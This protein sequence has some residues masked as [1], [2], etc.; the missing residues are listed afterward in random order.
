LNIKI[1]VKEKLIIVLKGVALGVANKVPGISGGLVAFV[2]GFY[3]EFIDSLQKFNV[4]GVK[5]IKQGKFK[6][7]Y[8]HINGQFLGLLLFGMI[9]SYFSVSRILDYLLN[10]Y[11][12]YVWSLFFG[13]IIGS[14]LF[15]YRRVE[16]LKLETFFWTLLGFI[17]GLSLS[18]ITPAGQN[19]NLFFVFIC[20]IVSVVGMTLPGFS[21][22]FILMLMGNYVL[23][24]V[25]SVNALYITLSNLFLGKFEILTDPYLCKMLK[26]LLVFSFGSLVGLILFSNILK[27]V[28]KKYKNKTLSTIMGFIAGSLAVV[29][30]WKNKIYKSNLNGEFIIDSF[31]NKQ[32]IDYSHYLPNLSIETYLGIVCILSGIIIVFIIDNT[33]ETIKSSL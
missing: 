28:L 19:E 21:G 14:L 24:L 16:S 12:I 3:E 22:S 1:A 20:G 32:I 25:D 13:L 10:H 18:L 23:L 9:V 27:F 31:N 5:L 4:E 30:P 15:I 2:L 17:F 6:I 11:E 8:R 7:F 33:E 26:I 29:W